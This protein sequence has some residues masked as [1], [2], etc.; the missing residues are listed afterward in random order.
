MKRL[1]PLFTFLLITSSSVLFGQDYP[2]EWRRFTK[3]GYISDIQHDINLSGRSETDF[4]N[5]LTDIART[6]IG[7]QIQIRICDLASLN[8]VSI[9]G[10]SYISYTSSTKFSTDLNIKLIETKVYYNSFTKEGY[11]IAYIDE[12]KA[13]STYIKD[14]R[15]I[16]NKIITV[17]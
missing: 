16:Y 1:A 10:R 15:I 14:V 17:R 2:S 7:K 5:Y 3:A 9:N 13:I 12:S 4:K 6:N 8:K 11:S